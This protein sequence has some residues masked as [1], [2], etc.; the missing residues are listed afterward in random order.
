MV[1]ER[2][3]SEDDCN[4]QDKIFRNCRIANSFF[5]LAQQLWIDVIAPLPPPTPAPAPGATSHN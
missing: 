5:P 3:P 1:N 2:E 4:L